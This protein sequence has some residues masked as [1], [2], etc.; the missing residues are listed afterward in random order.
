MRNKQ[1][2]ISTALTCM[3]IV[4]LLSACGD[5]KPVAPPD[6]TLGGES[7]LSL[8]TVVG[9]ENSGELT[10]MDTPEMKDDKSSSTSA[11]GSSCQY[12]YAN[13]AVGGEAVRQYAEKL[14]AE[15]EGFQVVDEAGTMAEAPDYS[16]ESG[17]VALA[18]TASEDGKILRIDISWTATDCSIVLTRPN[19]EVSE[20]PVEPMT[21][22]E[23]VDYIKSLPPAMLELEG[24]NMA[25]Y[26]V[27]PMDGAVMVDNIMCLKLQ[28]YPSPPP[29][30]AN[31]IAGTYLLSGDKKHIYLLEDET[32][33]ELPH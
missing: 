17:S 30:K 16:A 29:E 26:S 4:F 12:T 32:V 11:G 10:K 7:V 3:G 15:D 18:K 31:A 1:F 22:T 9:E 5:K 13:L 24:D 2:L 8:N 33:R 19:G 28:I 25:G 23:A 14:V 21:Y 6:Y 27:Y 20:P